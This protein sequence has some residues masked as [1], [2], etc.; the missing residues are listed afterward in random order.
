MRKRG[1]KRI[2]PEDH[3]ELEKIPTRTK[4][5]NVSLHV[6]KRLL[7]DLRWCELNR[8]RRHPLRLLFGV[9]DPDDGLE[10]FF[11]ILHLVDERLLHELGRRC[12]ER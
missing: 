7:H 3:T 8:T 11:G 4:P 6:R 9:C 1:A 5:T 12:V 10:G 2:K